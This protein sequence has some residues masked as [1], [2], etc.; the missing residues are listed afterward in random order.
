[1]R[2]LICCTLIAAAACGITSPAA[3]TSFCPV[4]KTADGFV[5]LRA[6]PGP[7]FALVVRM[8]ADD[9]VQLL[10]GQRGSWVEVRHWHGSERLEEKTRDKFRTG[11]VNKR[12]LGDCG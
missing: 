1:M 8:Q 7:G 12:Y 10:E 6:G 3:A 2:A 11:W 5:A 9:E 4:R